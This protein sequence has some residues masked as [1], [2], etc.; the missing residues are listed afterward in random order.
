MADKLWCGKRLSLT[1]LTSRIRGQQNFGSPTRKRHEIESTAIMDALVQ[2]NGANS[3]PE[4][5]KAVSELVARFKAGEIKK[6]DFYMQVCMWVIYYSVTHFRLEFESVLFLF[7]WGVFYFVAF[8]GALLW[9]VQTFCKCH[10]LYCTN[11]DPYLLSRKNMSLQLTAVYRGARPETSSEEVHESPKRPQQPVPTSN[12]R[13]SDSRRSSGTFEEEEVTSGT[14]RRELLKRLIEE[15][16][17]EAQ[18]E[19]ERRQQKAIRRASGQ[20]SPR[21]SSHARNQSLEVAKNDLRRSVTDFGTGILS[22]RRHRMFKKEAQQK[23]GSEERHRA[24]SPIQE[25]ELS[26]QGSTGSYDRMPEGGQ[27]NGYEEEQD[28]DGDRYDPE[29]YLGE[30]MN[31]LRINVNNAP[32]HS[33]VQSAMTVSE[34]YSEPPSP[35]P[36][37]RVR[38]ARDTIDRF[39]PYAIIAKSDSANSL[40]SYESESEDEMM[41]RVRK[42]RTAR[43]MK[44]NLEA[45][46]RER[47]CTFKPEIHELPEMYTRKKN[48]AAPFYE[49]TMKWWKKKEEKTKLG[50]LKQGEAEMKDCSFQPEINEKSAKLVKNSSEEQRREQFEQKARVRSKIAK[51]EAQTREDEEF[52]KHCT[53]KPKV[54]PTSIKLVENGARER[55]AT[56]QRRRNPVRQKDEEE[57]A[58]C[59]FHPKINEP[60]R[61]MDRAKQYLKEDPWERLNRTVNIQRKRK[62]GSK[63]GSRSRPHSASHSMSMGAS[64]TAG[65]F[66]S[67]H[68][69]TSPLG[70]QQLDSESLFDYDEVEEAVHR[71]HGSAMG[72]H[73]SASAESELGAHWDNFLSRLE[74]SEAKRLRNIQRRQEEE[75][76]KIGKPRLNKKSKDMIE[77]GLT[78]GPM[79][80]TTFF[81]RV[82]YSS[83]LR[84]KHHAHE[85][86]DK[87][88][89]FH[90]KISKMAQTITR[91]SPHEMSQGDAHKRNMKI[92]HT[93][94]K[95][96]QEELEDATF[97]PK[98]VSSESKRNLIQSRLGLD[99]DVSLYTKRLKEKQERKEALSEQ[100]R[101]LMQDEE[102][103][104]CT[105]APT[106]NEA[107]SYVQQIASSMKFAKLTSLA[108]DS[109]PPN[110]NDRPSFR[111]S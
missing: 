33:D 39:S 63:K 4:T 108:A 44:L 30:R 75:I 82:E 85:Q 21:Q 47:R 91:R 50:S 57:L 45:R 70:T 67:P 111:F 54:N 104:D 95:K 22:S 81:E 72:L 93:R 107:P 88:C 106:I 11:T 32:A 48:T 92:A 90:P 31:S 35:R 2:R 55:S 46:E 36:Q 13:E 14:S 23:G 43:M 64:R 66:S 12:E 77:K 68:S 10:N 105:F 3:T 1:V 87:E 40:G 83:E 69:A 6:A 102:E 20:A 29:S 78:I 109:L 60:L 86:F 7:V 26:R 73:H 52:E 56:N 71:A 8:C 19:K 17:M 110:P 25:E 99:G 51:L 103:K 59:T 61:T 65:G 101:K 24:H 34:G 79:G 97:V 5:Q 18:K 37:Q 27:R 89:T 74:Q 28:E 84:K 49:R 38:S 100:W 76:E 58:E 96:V 16:K 42:R 80:G 98:M 9:W 94:T 53:F 15:R 41:K 62:K